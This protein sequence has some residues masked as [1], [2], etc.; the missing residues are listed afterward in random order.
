A[1]LY[2]LPITVQG[3]VLDEQ[4]LKRISYRL[5]SGCCPGIGLEEMPG[6]VH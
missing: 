4:L 5:F 2:H 1:P 3:E 6:E